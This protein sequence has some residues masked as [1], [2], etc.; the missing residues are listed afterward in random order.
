MGLE[1]DIDVASP[2]GGVSWVPA[3]RYFTQFD[4]ALGQ[5]W[6]GRIW[7][8]PPFSK[9][10]PW[11]EKFILHG[12]GVTLLPIAKSKFIDLITNASDG[13]VMLPAYM[14]FK[15]PNKL[16]MIRFPCG[17]FAIGEEN[18]EGI[19]KVGRLFIP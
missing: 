14:K 4:D 8:N 15:G 13:M 5:D 11:V 19:A 9:V 7:M 16:G 6:T 12:N 17:L 10:T 2:P 18:V 3:K 1:F